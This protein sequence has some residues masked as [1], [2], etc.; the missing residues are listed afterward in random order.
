[1]N[2]RRE[3]DA[4]SARTNQHRELIWNQIEWIQIKARVEKMQRDI[5]PGYPK[6]RDVESQARTETDGEVTS[7][8]IMGS[9][10]CH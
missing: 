9:A 2:G 4:I 8:E 1:M 7:S 6:W 3:A 10:P 5:F